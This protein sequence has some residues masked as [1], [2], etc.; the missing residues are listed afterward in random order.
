MVTWGGE[1]NLRFKPSLFIFAFVLLLLSFQNCSPL[2]FNSLDQQLSSLTNKVNGNGGGY[3]GKPDNEYLRYLPQ[4]SCEGKESYKDRIYIENGKFFL[5]QTQFNQ[6]AA[7]PREL[8]PSELNHSPFQVDFIVAL[9]FLFKYYE[10][11]PSG[12]PTHLPEALCRDDFDNPKFEIITHYDSVTKTSNGRIYFKDSSG[13]IQ[14]ANDD[15]I[16]RLFSGGAVDY[17][18]FD[19]SLKMKLDLS[20]GDGANLRRFKATVTSLPSFLMSQS[21]RLTCV[22]GGGLDS[23]M[24]PLKEIVDRKMEAI[25]INPLNGDV[26]FEG[27]SPT[28]VNWS[29]IYRLKAGR[30]YQDVST[31]IFGSGH[32]VRHFQYIVNSKYMFVTGTQYG[33]GFNT[34]GY[35]FDPDTLGSVKMVYN[36]GSE[37][38]E[39]FTESIGNSDTKVVQAMPGIFGFDLQKIIWNNGSGTFDDHFYRLYDYQANSK[40]DFHQSATI[41]STIYNRDFTK[42]FSFVNDSLMVTRIESLEL[43]TREVRSYPLPVVAGCSTIYTSNYWGPPNFIFVDSTKEIIYQYQ[44]SSGD[45]LTYILNTVSGTTRELAKGK[46]L[47]WTSSDGD[48]TLFGSASATPGYANALLIS[49]NPRSVA[50]FK[51]S[52]NFWS[53]TSIDPHLTSSTDATSLKYFL[54]NTYKSGY[55][56]TLAHNQISGHLFGL[57]AGTTPAL[58]GFDSN[59]GQEKL[60]C[61]SLTNEK[62]LFIGDV[63]GTNPYLVTYNSQ[64]E[65]YKYYGLSM[66]Q[67]C[68]LINSFPSTRRGV[69]SLIATPLGIAMGVTSEDEIG[70]HYL[71]PD[72]VVFLSNTGRAALHLNPSGREFSRLSQLE[73]ASDGK[74]LFLVGYTGN[75][76]VNSSLYVFEPDK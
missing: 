51:A 44:C 59:Q 1:L 42:A 41:G 74:R 55:N 14:Q 18:G 57:S 30:A 62:Y 13:Q 45:L 73:P 28:H 36:R 31:D 35:I 11:T 49:Y 19:A 69:R 21:A 7:P 2:G 48:L 61:Q 17:S 52:T 16:A 47:L 34:Y 75:D 46:T 8:L 39:Y 72:T 23:K 66:D 3:E 53:N 63:K 40:V 54:P 33:D 15:S 24:W 50:A 68:K 29:R 5:Q 9:D 71:N 60:L 76:S 6:C 43:A 70:P 64:T 32:V 20:Q 67:G 25:K 4:Y 12:I 22:T 56:A 38:S 27:R 65:T 10:Y 37:R 58:F 26:F